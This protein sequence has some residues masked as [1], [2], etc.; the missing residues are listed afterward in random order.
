M[1]RAA[2]EISLKAGCAWQLWSWFHVL[3]YQLV[4]GL[5]SGGVWLAD[6]LRK[7][8]VGASDSL[9]RWRQWRLL[10]LDAHR[11]EMPAPAGRFVSAR[12]A[13]GSLDE[14]LVFA[15][16]PHVPAWLSYTSADDRPETY[17][18]RWV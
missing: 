11:F 10:V 14:F 12:R 18:F 17:D 15:Q 1:A 9:A 6:W 7:H 8:A 16:H 4:A 13:A 3:W 2:G 5:R